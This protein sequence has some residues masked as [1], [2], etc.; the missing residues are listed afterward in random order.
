MCR[1]QTANA[2]EASPHSTNNIREGPIGATATLPR[3]S[4]DNL[5]NVEAPSI[6]T[7]TLFAFPCTFRS[8]SPNPS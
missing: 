3:F 8:P 2:I 7:Q 1:L 4:F 5:S 6:C